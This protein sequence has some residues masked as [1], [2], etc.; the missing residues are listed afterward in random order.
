M[1][2]GCDVLLVVSTRESCSWVM[3]GQ[4]QKSRQIGSGVENGS[5][6]H[7]PTEQQRLK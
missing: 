2:L 5:G 6:S 1:E 4:E 7:R 3:E